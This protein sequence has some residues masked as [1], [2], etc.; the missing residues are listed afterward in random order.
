MAGAGTLCRDC[1]A[2]RHSTSA[3]ARCPSCGSPRQISHDELFDLSI[4][5]VDCDA[6][7][8]SVEKRDDPSLADKP[9]IIGGGVRGVVSTACYLARIKGVRSAMPM[10]KAQALCPE[11]VIVK[12]NMGKY[13]DAS[14]AIRTKFNALTPLVEPL[15]VDEAF[16]DLTGTE[17]LHHRTPA[18]TLAQLALDVERDVGITISV[19]LA[20][21]K[22]LA[23]VASDLD[24]PRGF[25]VIGEAEKVDFL[26]RQP[27]TLI[28]GVGKAFAAS[29]AKDGFRTIADLQAAE[30]D[31]LFRRYGAMGGRLA[32]L[33]W[34]EDARLVS[35]DHRAKSVSAETTFNEDIAD[36]AQLE[37]HLWHLCERVGGRMKAK[38]VSGRVVTLKLKTK[39]FK[40]RTRRATLPE[41]SALA[42]TLYHTGQPLLA[43]EVTGREAFRLIGIGFSDLAPAAK[44][45]GFADL[46]DP[47][48]SA[49]AK[50]EQAIDSIRNRFGNNAIAKGRSF[51]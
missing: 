20:P 43:N 44:C 15:S 32:R 51:R 50:A 19:G 4:A 45:D 38:D 13:T 8:A 39:D 26:A 2:T 6:F 9:V 28:W 29:L 48:A 27:V 36:L 18:E 37:S 25:S 24:K 34:G 5:H 17:R 10:F 31:L 41:P 7:F 30:P 12:P 21:N 11:A 42:D 40:T 16:L 47:K 33:A 46:L 22:F 35:T 49:R 14:R 23:K 1:G 3:P